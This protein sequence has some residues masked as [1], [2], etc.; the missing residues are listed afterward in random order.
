MNKKRKRFY[1]IYD[2]P[3]IFR[4]KDKRILGATTSVVKL[5]TKDFIKAHPN[6]D[7]V[8]LMM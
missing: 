7:S 8:L 6:I 1:N 4:D 2:K 3:I 5:E